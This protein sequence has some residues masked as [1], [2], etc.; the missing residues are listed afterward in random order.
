MVMWK[1]ILHQ[2]K[3]F[4]AYDVIKRKNFE[5]MKT[6]NEDFAELKKKSHDV[7]R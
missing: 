7:G 6:V 4:V 2:D 1:E 3:L 5:T